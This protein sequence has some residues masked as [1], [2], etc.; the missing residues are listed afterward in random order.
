VSPIW[1][2]LAALLFLGVSPADEHAAAVEEARRG[3][4]V[5]ALATL[6]RL[7]AENP[8][9]E[10]IR[11]DRIAVLAWAGRDREALDL[12]S[13]TDLSRGPAWLL[14]ILG[15]CARNERE[16]PRA[17]AYYRR[18]LELAPDR[19]ES[20]K[21]LAFAL[22]T[23]GRGAEARAT[24][25][26]APAG[27]VPHRADLEEALG[28]LAEIEGNFTSALSHYQDALDADPRRREARRGMARALWRLGGWGPL[29]AMLR[30]DPTL[31]DP[32]ESAQVRADFTAQLIRWGRID[33]RLEIGPS[34]FARLDEA[35]AASQPAAEKLA[36]DPAGPISGADWTL[37][38]DR[39]IALQERRRFA[40]A[41]ALHDLLASVPGRTVPA[42]ATAAAGTS[43]LERR[44][45]ARAVPLL[46]QALPAMTA[47]SEDWEQTAITLY[48]ALDDGGRPEEAA[49]RLD[50]WI[51]A[52][53]RR[54]S[55]GRANPVWLEL[56]LLHVN[57]LVRA[58]QPAL[59]Q[60]EAEALRQAAP[61]QSGVREAQS[62]VSR[63][64]DW[65]RRSL[66]ELRL[67]V[68][69]DP[70]DLA[71]RG[72][73]VDV[74]LELHRYEEALDA[75]ERSRA[76]AAD[77]SSVKRAWRTW[78][79]FQRPELAFDARYQASSDANPL[80]SQ[81]WIANA[82]GFTPPLALHWRLFAHAL[83]TGATFP[84]AVTTWQRGAAGV[85]WTPPDWRLRLDLSEG[86]SARLGAKLSGSWSVDDH[87]SADA[88]VG[89]VTNAVPMQAW[90]AGVLIDLDTALAA[91][92]AWNESTRAAM[93]LAWL[94]FSDGNQRVSISGSATQRLHG[95][96]RFLVAGT[97]G[98]WGGLNS[99][100]NAP[101]FNPASAW[102]S[103]VELTADWFTWQRYEHRFDQRLT[104]AAGAS[105]QVNY[106]AL[107]LWSARYEHTWQFGRNLYLKYGILASQIP[108][109]GAATLALGGNLGLDWRF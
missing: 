31:L 8:G 56:R 107:P 96:A 98:L 94:G 93:S 32:A 37:L 88:H 1:L 11:P 61:F 16:L 67:L 5:Q 4:F 57:S 59:A 80:G 104:L 40:D 64:R 38:C 103:T 53:P 26:A 89:T 51:A 10:S 68:A 48:Y 62:S 65:P 44:D 85:E 90:R 47:G 78:E 30:E 109:D 76:R 60:S 77:S 95:S 86:S 81:E 20:R 108:Y 100:A 71:D 87:W 83:T 63:A 101:Y 74:L 91:S 29:Q 35:I 2:P 70:A 13:R 19:F 50:G 28:Q 99:L 15:R 58:N 97:L 24:L 92:H 18:A 75:L 84:G 23:Q 46:E 66:E 42:Y 27:G 39:V 45:P 43:W 69:V 7:E 106:G 9:D 25:G 17:E 14:E 22:A 82:W 6:E 34:R 49:A 21:G 102:S 55:D 41:T 54:L 105:W 72:R 52:T 36:A 33:E 12:A 79:T 73:E 3:D